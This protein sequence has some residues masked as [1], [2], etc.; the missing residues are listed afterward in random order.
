MAAFA[1]ALGTAAAI[2]VL[3]WKGGVDTDRLILVGIGVGA[4]VVAGTTYLTVRFPLE[5]VRPAE[6]WLMGS[7]C[8]S[9]WRDVVILLV[10][11]AVVPAHCRLALPGR[12]APCSSATTSLA[13]SASRWNDFA[14]A[15]LPSAARWPRFPSPLPDRSPSWP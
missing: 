5:L 3:T 4:V 8:G 11:L 9:T 6:F 2:Y 12:C 15:S 10:V 1:G 14:W 13:A 7:L